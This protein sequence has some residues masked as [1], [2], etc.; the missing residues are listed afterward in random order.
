MFLR[1]FLKLNCRTLRF[2]LRPIM[3]SFLNI[4]MNLVSLPYGTKS[5]SDWQV[6]ILARDG[7]AGLYRGFVPNA[8][9]SLPNSRFLNIFFYLVN[10]AFPSLLYRSFYSSVIFLQYSPDN[11][12]YRE[13]SHRIKPKGVPDI[14]RRKKQKLTGINPCWF[15]LF[16]FILLIVY[17]AQMGRRF[18]GIVLA[19]LCYLPTTAELDRRKVGLYSDPGI[20]CLYKFLT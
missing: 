19:I 3:L 5:K 2:C 18:C 8:L 11:V 6:G 15:F 13:M 10:G 4:D 12:W 9:K 7:V 14:D 17:G 20:Y 16:C 1:L